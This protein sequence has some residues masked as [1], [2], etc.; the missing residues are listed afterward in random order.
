MYSYYVS[1]SLNEINGDGD[2]E[3]STII[4]ANATRYNVILIC[5][6]EQAENYPFNR[7]HN[8]KLMSRSKMEKN[9]E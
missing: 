5:T 7:T 3:N 1:F 9:N 8:R 4:I 2:Q 6:Q